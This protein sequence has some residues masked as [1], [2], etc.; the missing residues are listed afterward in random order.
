MVNFIRYNKMSGSQN[1]FHII[2]MGRKICI[3]YSF[4]ITPFLN[5]IV[6]VYTLFSSQII[7]YNLLMS[8]Q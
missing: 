8:C 4:S 1:I 2:T 6:E 7:K 5:K 3:N